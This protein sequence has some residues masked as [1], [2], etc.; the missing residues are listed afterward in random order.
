[1]A[2]SPARIGILE[3][4]QQFDQQVEGSTEEFEEG[5]GDVQQVDLMHTLP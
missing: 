5:L 3:E 2:L 1:M 4:D